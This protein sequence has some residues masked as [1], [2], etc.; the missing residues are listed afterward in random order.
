LGDPFLNIPEERDKDDLISLHFSTEQKEQ[1][2]KEIDKWTSINKPSLLNRINE[3]ISTEQNHLQLVR[4]C[5][6]AFSSGSKIATETGYEFQCAEPLIE[7]SSEKKGNS[8]FDLLI[9]NES[10]NRAIFVECKSSISNVNEV[11]AQISESKEHVKDRLPYISD[12][13]EG[14][15]QFE[16]CE[17]VLC[18]TD[19]AAQKVIQSITQKQ[20]KER[21]SIST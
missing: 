4:L 6:S 2:K 14:D 18:A 21:P 20:K 1:Y 3:E 10:S 12:R 5:A 13:I 17:F 15:L 7:F 8:S 19:T 11:Y 16:N 9:F